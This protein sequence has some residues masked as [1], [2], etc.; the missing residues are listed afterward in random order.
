MAGLRE[1]QKVARQRRILEAA[2]QQFRDAD[3]R[4]V[5]VEAIAAAA[6]LSSMTVFNYYGSKGGL[7]LAL[8]AESDR[9]LIRKINT[10]LEQRHD[11]PVEAVV[12]FSRTII[13]HGFSYLNR[14]TWR[15]VLA[16]AMLEGSSSFGHGFM[17]LEREL[18]GLLSLL[19]G[20]L[21][22]RGHID[23]DCDEGV[24]ARVLYNAHNAHFMAYAADP[25][26]SRDAVDAM[27]A[28]DLR[29]VVERLAPTA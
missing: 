9:H 26:L 1:R 16:T 18:V 25:A 17:A 10:V 12:R 13:D 8:V 3:Y 29:F 22:A 11:D 14:R 28:E 24:A 21:K 20:R 2:R 27:V 6:E 5:T 15:H 7:L 23:P 19:L 4:D